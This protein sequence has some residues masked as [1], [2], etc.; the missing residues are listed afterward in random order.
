MQ[1]EEFIK[2]VSIR[3]EIHS[4]EDT[5][6]ATKAVF[7]T[8][9]ERIVHDTGDNIKSQLPQGIQKLWETGLLQHIA[10]KAGRPTRMDLSGFIGRVAD[11]L[12]TGDFVYAER[13]SRAVITTLRQS[14]TPGAQ[15]EVLYELPEDLREFWKSATP[16]EMP[17]EAEEARRKAREQHIQEGPPFEMEAPVEEEAGAA[18][19]AGSG[20][21][22]PC[23]EEPGLEEV[24]EIDVIDMR[25]KHEVRP[26][27]EERMEIVPPPGMRD[28]NAGPGSATHYRSDPQ[29]EEEIR[30]MLEESDE[31]EADNID[32]QVLAGNITLRGHVKSEERR[33]QVGHVAAKALGVGDILNEIVVEEKHL[34]EGI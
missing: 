2:L 5:E 15:D 18:S 33:D 3:G 12:E 8:L 14:I 6:N 13:V 9:K 23:A 20:T 27:S 17:M 11:R 32:V 1:T 25:S 4:R 24:T 30:Q 10:E 7:Q 28:P 21:C 19:W 22:E 29:L 26:P 16:P 31:L 34:G